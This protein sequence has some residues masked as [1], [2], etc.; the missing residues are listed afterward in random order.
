MLLRAQCMKNQLQLKGQGSHPE[1]TAT[2]IVIPT[3]E[4][5]LVCTTEALRCQR[6]QRLGEAGDAGGGAQ[7]MTQAAARM[8]VSHGGAHLDHSA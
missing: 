4:A 6:K 7:A 1:A 8:V 5:A 2:I 3:L